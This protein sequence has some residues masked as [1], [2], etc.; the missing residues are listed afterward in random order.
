MQSPNQNGVSEVVTW[1]IRLQ[2]DTHTPYETLRT[3]RLV[4]IEHFRLLQVAV[5]NASFRALF[6]NSSAKV[7]VFS[8]IIA[9][10][11]AFTEGR[12]EK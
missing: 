6:W 7:L 5:L 11:Y 10:E 1:Q 2:C 3:E 4:N 9:R 12:C 8:G